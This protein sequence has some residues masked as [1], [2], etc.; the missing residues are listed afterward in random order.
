MANSFLVSKPAA[1][2][3]LIF[4]LTTL[5][6]ISISA[7][8]LSETSRGRDLSYSIHL[9]DSIVSADVSS[10]SGG[11]VTING[12]VT[13]TAA[14]DVTI[15]LE[16]YTINYGWD[17][18]IS[19][20]TLQFFK[21]GS[22]SREFIVEVKVPHGTGADIS[23]IIQVNGTWE[24]LGLKGTI[25]PETAV[26]NILQYSSVSVQPVKNYVGFSDVN[27][28]I[29]FPVKIKNRGNGDD[30]F[31][32][33]LDDGYGSDFGI[34]SRISLEYGDEVEETLLIT[35]PDIDN[36]ISYTIQLQVKSAAFD[37]TVVL[38]IKAYIQNGRVV[39][40]SG[41]GP[42]LI[43]HKQFEINTANI[44]EFTPGMTGK[45]NVEVIAL[46]GDVHDITFEIK[47]GRR[48]AILYKLL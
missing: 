23:E 11:L 12:S 7:S 47:I 29:E 31:D 24:T 26:V 5:V 40:A 46:L 6:V 25:A 39:V 3:G 21:T 14:T 9:E 4:L 37:S 22:N 33:M 1:R 36:I 30:S 18:T 45:V 27:E 28:L 17:T 43:V 13:L 15:N 8:A 44:Q 34:P 48:N 19:P 10:Q 42:F 38:E 2:V 41:I 32:I 20:S 16:G 35:I